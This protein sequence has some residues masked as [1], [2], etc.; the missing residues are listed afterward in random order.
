MT[1]ALNRRRAIAQPIVDQ[2]GDYVLAL[3]GNQG[4]LRDDV[5]TFL[6]DPAC[7]AADTKPTVDAN[8]GCIRT[9]AA[10]VSIDI[11]WLQENHDTPGV[12]AISK[13]VR[14]RE[15]AAKTT[16]ETAYYLLSTA[17][18]DDRFNEIVRQRRGSK[19]ACTGGSMS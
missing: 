14:V 19:I 8:H 5:K 2:A 15:T 18:S 10:T 16:T 13:V 7:K 9:R 6:D 11:S 17:L 12:A 3:K 1:D 4:T